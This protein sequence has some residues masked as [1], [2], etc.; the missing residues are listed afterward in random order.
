MLKLLYQSLRAP[1]SSAY[2]NRLVRA[3]FEL[4]ALAVNGEVRMCFP[5]FPAA[6]GSI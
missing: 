3:V 2:D 4:K 6:A 5:V 1:A